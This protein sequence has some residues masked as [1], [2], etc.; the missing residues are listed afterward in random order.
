MLTQKEEDEYILQNKIHFETLFKKKKFQ[1]SL[2]SVEIIRKFF[3]LRIKFSY[4]FNHILLHLLRNT[5]N[6]HMQL[7]FLYSIPRPDQI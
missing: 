3:T 5:N 7:F 6:P 2:E 4:L 1:F